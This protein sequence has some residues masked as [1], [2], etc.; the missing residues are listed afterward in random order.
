MLNW[1]TGG[2]W[3]FFNLNYTISMLFCPCTDKEDIGEEF[4]A[5]IWISVIFEVFANKLWFGEY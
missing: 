4:L 1:I 2:A 3:A 5:F